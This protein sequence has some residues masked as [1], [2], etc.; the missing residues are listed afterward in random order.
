MSNLFETTF[1]SGSDGATIVPGSEGFDS[2]TGTCTYTAATAAHGQYSAKIEPTG[3]VGHLQWNAGGYL[4]GDV[5]GRAYLR[6]ASAPADWFH[7]ISFFDG[8]SQKASIVLTADNRVALR[9]SS[10]NVDRVT[11]G[12]GAWAPLTWIRIEWKINAASDVFEAWIYATDPDGTT[13]DSHIVVPGGIG[14]PQWQFIRF[15]IN[16]ATGHPVNMLYDNLAISQTGKIGASPPDPDPTPP[17]LVSAWVGGVDSSS[18]Q[19]AFHLANTTNAQVAYAVDPGTGDPLTGTPS[20]TPTLGV[21]SEG[22]GQL[23]L[24]GLTADTDY[25]YGLIADGTLLA[26]RGHFS[27]MPRGQTDFMVA[28]SS[29]QADASDHAIFDTIRTESPKVFFHLGDLYATTLASNDPVA[30]RARYASQLAA[31][32]GRFRHLTKDVPVDYVWNTTDWGGAHSDST[33]TAASALLSAYQDVVPSYPLIDA[34]SALY[35]AVTIGRVQ[36][37]VLD[38]RSRRTTGTILGADQKAWLKTQ[39]SSSTTPVKVIV[40]PI[41]WRTGTEWDDAPGELAELNAYLTDNAITNVAMFGAAYAVAA[42]S[43][44]NSS[45]NR[46]NL[47]AGALDGTGAAAA[48]TWSVGNHANAAAA[49]QYALLSVTDTGTHITLTYSGRNQADTVQ[50]GP[51]NVVFTITASDAPQVKKWN[52]TD[53]ILFQPRVYLDGIWKPVPVK[54]YDGSAWQSL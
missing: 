52:G 5:W 50:V 40:C 39:L 45:V 19:I 44:A 33:Y 48:G 42:D 47:L 29:G 3:N 54:Y 34:N 51:Y 17:A 8:G 28:F 31:G 18:A 26:D 9:N 15:G 35:H 43:G 21:S 1:E 37:L 6:V 14:I 32:T 30:A 38:V 41:P 25:V 10:V 11:T 22:Y 46:A 27:T 12:G 36:F 20:T 53:W 2:S 24:S 4:T 7:A 23:A 16:A 13:E 49:G